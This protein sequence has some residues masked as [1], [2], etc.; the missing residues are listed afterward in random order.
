MRP[1]S[2][3]T[4]SLA[5]LAAATCL[6]APSLAAT[7]APNALEELPPELDPLGLLGL[8]L[9]PHAASSPNAANAA[10]A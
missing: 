3:T 6:T 9:L 5:L 2:R 10:A 4:C 7:P 1:L 8:F